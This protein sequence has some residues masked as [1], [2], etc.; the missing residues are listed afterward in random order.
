MST[1][2]PIVAITGSPG[3]GRSTISNAFREIFLRENINAEYV[4]GDA[5]RRF[6]QDDM[7][8]AVIE[9][10]RQN[11]C[12]S[13]FG[14]DANE[15]A[16]LELLFHH[17]G[18]SATGR[19]RTYVNKF[20]AEELVQEPGSFTP[21]RDVKED[22]D[23]LFYEGLHGGVMAQSWTRRSMSPSHN[24]R[25]VK[26]RRQPSRNAGVDVAQY[27]DL[28]IGVVPVVNL[29]WIQKIH[30]DYDVK[31]REASDATT[32]ILR[33]MRDYIHFMVPQFSLTDIN[34]QRVPLVDTSNPFVAMDVPNPEESML[35]IRFRDPQRHDF[36][37]LLERFDN[38]FMSRPNT[39]VIPGGKLRHS[40]EV[41]CQ[42]MIHGML[43][44]SRA[45][46]STSA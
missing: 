18:E 8:M 46:D 23:L 39:M 21:W 19:T 25:V 43:E 32:N 10:D 20:N 1:Q 29:E 40:L 42:P 36:P 41:I 38:S 16:A 30:R 14:P 17:Y 22:T 4:K 2:H 9:A 27:V 28:L 33:R 13:H 6:N 35:V 11:R 12:I 24:P 44:A 45:S 5:F 34:F 37:M 15:F 3:S 26:E 7:H 31:G